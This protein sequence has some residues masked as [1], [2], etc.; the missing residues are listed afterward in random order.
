M[1]VVWTPEFENQLVKE[2]TSK[3]DLNRPL[4]KFNIRLCSFGTYLK[5]R[6]NVGTVNYYYEFEA[7]SVLDALLK[8][9]SY[10]SSAGSLLQYINANR[11]IED[12]LKE[13]M[14]NNNFFSLTVINPK[15]NKFVSF[16]NKDVRYII[17]SI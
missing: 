4:F 17:P 16:K 7:T 11:P 12:V 10:Y 3:V 5:G 1:T 13:V 15:T 14:L 9:H 8:I 2:L 6:T